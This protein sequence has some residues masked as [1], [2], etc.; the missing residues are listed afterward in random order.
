MSGGTTT[1][2]SRSGLSIWSSDSERAAPIARRVA[3]G[4][5]GVNGLF[6]DWAVPFGGMKCSGL[7]REF[8]VDDLREFCNTQAI[9]RSSQ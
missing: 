9:H 4:N 1:V 8:G 2:H 5:I 7:G 3:A 6:L